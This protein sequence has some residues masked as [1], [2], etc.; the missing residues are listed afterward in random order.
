V[1]P[2]RAPDP[3]KIP[4][5]PNGNLSTKTEGADVWGYEWNAR[6]ELTRV[7]KNA[8][9]QARFAYD[10]I[11]RRVEKVAG[12][13]TTGYTYDGE[14]ILQQTQGALVLKYIQGPSTDEPL[15]VDDGTGLSF[16][17]ADAL[18]SVVKQSSSAGAIVLTRQYDAWGNLEIGT[19]VASYA[20]T[21]REWDSELGLYYYRAR[22][23]DPRV[24][25]FIG[26]DPVA[27][28]DG[29]DLYSYVLGNPV[30]MTDP[31]GRVPE[32]PRCDASC[33]P[34][35]PGAFE[36]LC[37]YAMG[38]PDPEV[39]KCAQDKCDSKNYSLG[40]MSND[41][42]ACKRGFAM[43]PSTDRSLIC[44]WKVPGTGEPCMERV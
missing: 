33:R 24:S 41:A 42:E 1:A 15:A 7:T 5:D 30:L 8:V 2:F 26:E 18:G 44:H 29:G 20:F 27:R 6:N 19:S 36:N 32:E 21:G 11:G 12:G 17:H 14:D 37:K 38:I 16:L 34:E 22:Y 35:V 10:P 3:L 40:C 4:I 25:R 13:V 9:E 43:T 23:Y 31:S 39:R 28:D